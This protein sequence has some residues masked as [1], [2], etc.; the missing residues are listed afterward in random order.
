M[1]FDRLK[2]R[3]F[4]GLVGALTASMPFSGRAQQQA[5]T[6]GFLHQGFPEPLLNTNAFKKGLS[7]AGI[8]SQTVRIED[9]A[10]NGL[11]DRLPEL[12][13][14]L[15][16]HDVAVIAANFLPAA[17]AAKAATQIIPIVFLSGSDPI[18]SG[19]VSSINRPDGNVTG[20]APMFTL[21]ETK[22]LELLHEL[23]AGASVI[24]A[25]A[26]LTNPNM[27]HQLGDLRAAAGV[28]GLDIVVLSGK[29]EPEIDAS[30]ASLH[31]H[32]IGAVVV[33]AD[34]FL[35]SRQDQIVGLAARYAMPTMYPLSE[36]VLT[37]GLMSYGANLRDAFRQMGIYV[38]RIL[39]GM[40]PTDLPVL[41][42]TK[43]EFVINLKTAKALGLEIPPKLFA[44]A[45]EV[46]E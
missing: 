36:Y 25:L 6:I 3:E 21:L 14:E 37:G 11:Y 46:I 2:R 26:N 32:R 24:G 19:L 22:N 4:I 1:Q 16:A 23:A 45:D 29:D 35:I 34:G 31:E 20:I 27:E 39:K 38:G 28:I 15:V 44:L 41:Q 12:A 10:A 43:V 8:D 5:P 18:K 13:A 9:R 42:P 30:F 40:K 7:E 17:L 33:T